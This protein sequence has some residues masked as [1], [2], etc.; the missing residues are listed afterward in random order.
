MKRSRNPQPF[1]IWT[2]QR[3]GGTNLADA[4]FLL[5]TRNAAHIP[6]GGYPLPSAANQAR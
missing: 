4:E 6:N 2:L 1:I 3:T 5:N